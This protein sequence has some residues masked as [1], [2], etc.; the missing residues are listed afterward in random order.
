MKLKS[1][2]SWQIVCA[3]LLLL[4]ASYGIVRACAGGDWDETYTSNYTPEVFV[5]DTTQTPFFYTWLFYYQIGFDTQHNERFNATNVAD[6][7]RYLKGSIDAPS[8]DYLLN[9]ANDA[10]IGKF[11]AFF[12]GKALPDSLTLKVKGLSRSN[13]Q[14]KELIRYLGYAKKCE[15]YAVFYSDYY[16][17]AKRTLPSRAT[18][19]ELDKQLRTGFEKSTDLFLKERYWF[20]LVRYYFF[21][22]SE[23][24]MTEF[25]DN[26]SKFSPST[27]YYRTMAYAAGAYYAREEFGTA[28]YYYSLIYDGSSLLKTVAHASFHPQNESDWKQTLDLCKSKEER[29]TL[30]QMLGIRYADEVRS[31]K[32]IYKLSPR[33][34]KLDLLLTRFVNKQE[35]AIP[36]SPNSDSAKAAIAQAI[37]WCQ[38]VANDGK[39]SNPFLWNVSA[40]YL[41]FLTG[42]YPKS[43]Q[44][45]QKAA[46]SAPSSTLAQSQLR[47]LSLLTSIKLLPKITPASEQALLPD[48]QWLYALSQ[49]STDPRFRYYNAQSWVKT[50][51]AKKYTEQGDAIKAECF[52]TSSAF[53]ASNDNVERMKA[54]FQNTKANAFEKFCMEMS[55]KKLADLWEYQAIR[56]A[57]SDSLGKAIALMENVGQTGTLPG[58]PFVG[59]KN[60]CHDC[61]HAAPQKVK[62][63]KMA[64]LKRLKEAEAAIVG[65]DAYNNAFVVANAF[66]NMSHY[67][68][69]R[70]FYE[71]SVM[72]G[73]HYAPYAIPDEFVDML[74]SNQ[75][76]MRYYWMALKA[77]TSNEQKAKCLFML[78][79][80]ERNEWYNT[81]YYSNKEN[82]YRYD[83]NQIDFIQWSSFKALKAYSSTKFYKEILNECGYFR[84][85]VR[86]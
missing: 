30:W 23:R 59:R 51:L 74:T 4:A 46:K 39:T 64:F 32:E 86:G 13:P 43:A 28:N 80:C 5:A 18:L 31:M 49:D 84:K 35:T 12:D 45:Y 67:G 55:E 58:N 61:D 34:S 66:Y 83:P 16:W 17:E 53:Y 15:Q 1:T 41:S 7:S 22:D 52:A 21:Y 48:L 20:Q 62:Y 85:A 29:I 78:A 38:Q 65:K 69:A 14:H 54:F 26:R 72:G 76:A 81:T 71:C 33:S 36:Y 79:K 73:S 24:C 63:S 11:A 10:S 19:G 2:K 75:T 57:Y 50:E 9:K 44:Y 42:D 25:E 56:A 77:A 6:W 82:E 37:R 3:S 70:T 68:N 47:L 8:L 40:G 27:M 60:D